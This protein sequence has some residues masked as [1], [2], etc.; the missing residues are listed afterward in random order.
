M[1]SC[2]V[3]DIAVVAVANAT[4][5]VT[6][7]TEHGQYRELHYVCPHC[8]SVPPPVRVSRD[9]ATVASVLMQARPTFRQMRVDQE[10][11]DIVAREGLS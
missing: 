1:T 8:G 4:A 3:C 9:V 11:R 10:F 7:T 6:T 5:V 2:P